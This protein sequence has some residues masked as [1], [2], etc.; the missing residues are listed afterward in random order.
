MIP[1]E[2]QTAFRNCVS[3]RGNLARSFPTFHPLI[4]KGSHHRAGLGFGV[5]IIQVIVGITAVK[6]DRL[7]NQPL[8]DHL[9]EKVNILRVPPARAV[10]WWSPVINVFTVPPQCRQPRLPEIRYTGWCTA[11]RNVLLDE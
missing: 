9:S 11:A 4:A 1:P 5:G 6:Q 8:P 10:T 2:G 7:L 3:R